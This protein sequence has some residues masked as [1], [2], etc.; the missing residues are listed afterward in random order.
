MGENS[1]FYLRA[2]P[3]WGGTSHKS[4]C[5]SAPDLAIQRGKDHHH[6][7]HQYTNYTY[8]TLALVARAN[9]NAS[10]RCGAGCARWRTWRSRG[11]SRG[12]TSARGSRASATPRPSPPTRPST[13]T[14]TPTPSDRLAFAPHAPRGDGGRG[15]GRETGRRRTDAKG[16]K[17]KGW[18]ARGIERRESKGEG[19]K[20]GRNGREKGLKGGR[21]K[22]PGM[23]EKNNRGRGEAKQMKAGV[24]REKIRD[25]G[26]KKDGEKKRKRFGET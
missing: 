22:L 21:E 17:I 8:G 16:G 6:L 25:W 3:S 26:K 24:E 20:G 4:T 11:A 1:S 23:C 7:T 18:E 12:P 5:R 19:K 10:K 15:R 13:S 9:V 2:S 14:P